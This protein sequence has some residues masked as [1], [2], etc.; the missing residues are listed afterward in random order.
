MVQTR[1]IFMFLLLFSSL[2]F[3]SQP[4]SAVPTVFN[5]P[6][7]H[8]VSVTGNILWSEAN[9][10]C[11]ITYGTTLAS[12]HSS[13]NVIEI[14]EVMIKLGIKT[15]WIGLNDAMVEGKYVWAD[16]SSVDYLNWAVG[17]PND[18]KHLENFVMI[19]DTGLMSDVPENAPI[20]T[21]V[22]NKDTVNPVVV[23]KS[24]I[25][26]KVYS[27][28]PTLIYTV[29]DGTVSV[30]VDG[31]LN[32]SIVSGTKMTWLNDGDH[33]IEVQ[34]IDVA[35]NVG[36]NFTKFTIDTTKPVVKITSPL[37]KIYGGVPTLTYTVS[38]G[39]VS[40]YVD[41]VLNASIV[42][43]TK[44]TWLNDGFHL[45]EVRSTDAAGNVGNNFTRFTIDTTAPKV[46]ILSPVSSQTYLASVEVS[47]SVSEGSVSVILDSV[48]N[49]TNMDSGTVIKDLA[50]GKHTLKVTVTDLAGNVGFDEVSFI[51]DRTDPVVSILAPLNMTYHTNQ[52]I[53][54]YTVSEG[55]TYI[56]TNGV[57][58]S[59]NII[60][61]VTV[62]FLNE[63]TY[64]LT[65][66]AVDVVGNYAQSTVFFSIKLPSDINTSKEESN[67]SDTSTD[68]LSE[69]DSSTPS[70]SLGMPWFSISIF[71]LGFLTLRRYYKFQK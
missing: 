64:N 71:A 24:P 31:V 47:Y 6:N 70:F 46:E 36:S 30:Y 27:T 37:N 20:M 23:I 68:D 44:L 58:N 14:T 60:S 17:E 51:I 16:G 29:S 21:F 43:G 35:G 67:T 54:N 3:I 9:K 62:L 5:T 22:C 49:S 52:L 39:T 15:A 2:G 50:E 10:Y 28:I 66:Y 53:Y 25:Y 38:D 69:T 11:Q 40:V 19:N 26:K 18:N 45:I 7:Y 4:T 57:G 55:K 1:K 56:F 34:S 32:A 41:R 12:L 42:S 48:T 59:S 63:G 8:I 13:L 61:G 33:S 65:I